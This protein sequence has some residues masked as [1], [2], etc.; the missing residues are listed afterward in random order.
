MFVQTEAGGARAVLER[1]IAFAVTS[2][3]ENAKSMGA[4]KF[5]GASDTASAVGDASGA[6]D[7]KT[8]GRFARS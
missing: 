1:K 6:A 7:A 5:D 2:S 8:Q 3:R 4:A